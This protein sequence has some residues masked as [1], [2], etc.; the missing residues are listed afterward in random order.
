M[1]KVSSTPDMVWLSTATRRSDCAA[2][3]SHCLMGPDASGEM[4]WRRTIQRRSEA[5]EFALARFRF[6]LFS[7]MACMSRPNG[8]KLHGFIM[9]LMS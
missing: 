1:G 3:V 9:A 8:P 2:S 5:N 4:A 7:P 6:T